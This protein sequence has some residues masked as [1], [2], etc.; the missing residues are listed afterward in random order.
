MNDDVP[1]A[2]T[3]GAKWVGAT[4]TRRIC[5]KVF[6]PVPLG[7]LFV[8]VTVMCA[9]PSA[10]GGRVKVIEPVLSVPA[11]LGLV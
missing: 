7:S 5:E 6:E 10:G 2:F 4:S 1:A 3:W 11:G 8:T 9:L